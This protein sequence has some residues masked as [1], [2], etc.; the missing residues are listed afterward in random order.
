MRLPEQIHEGPL[1]QLCS[2]LSG[3][4]A[5]IDD[6]HML[7]FHFGPSIDVSFRACAFAALKKPM[8][9]SSTR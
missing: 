9:P 2:Q 4:R 8:T 3:C 6:E 5:D 7:P 1:W